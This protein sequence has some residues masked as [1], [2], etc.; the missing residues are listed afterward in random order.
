MHFNP[1]AQTVM[2]PGDVLIAMGETSKLWQ[3]EE[4]VAG[5]KT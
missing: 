4:Q 2:E 5:V 1:S 3:L